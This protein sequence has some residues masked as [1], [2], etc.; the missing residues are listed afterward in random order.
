MRAI[1]FKDPTENGS[2][3]DARLLVSLMRHIREIIPNGLL[4]QSK[5]QLALPRDVIVNRRRDGDQR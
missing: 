2:L 3:M 5:V 4:E 1:L